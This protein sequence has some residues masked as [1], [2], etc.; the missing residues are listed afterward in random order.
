[1][2]TIANAKN[3]EQATQA[4]DRL[5]VRGIIGYIYG[6]KS[7]GYEVMV[8]DSYE[9]VAKATLGTANETPMQGRLPEVT[10]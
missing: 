3:Y 6:C 9:V 5:L 1:M 10:A 7:R 2:K 4:T 8:N